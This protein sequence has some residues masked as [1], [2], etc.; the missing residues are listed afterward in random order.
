MKHLKKIERYTP[1]IIS[2][3]PQRVIPYHQVFGI[4]EELVEDYRKGNYVP[5]IP[6]FLAPEDL[7]DEGDYINYNG[8]HRTEAARRA[9]VFALGILLKDWRDILYLDHN[10]PF[11]KGD[12]YP[13]LIEGLDRNFKAHRDFII[14]S[15]KRFRKLR[16]IA[17]TKNIEL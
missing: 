3:N 14:Y 17:H 4:R 10:P 12:I 9:G 6:V 11:W 15:A 1:K 2:L 5:P 8:H 7:L 16:E 13:E